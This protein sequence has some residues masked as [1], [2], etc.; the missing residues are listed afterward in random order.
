MVVGKG[1][2]DPGLRRKLGEIDW[3]GEGGRCG[4]WSWGGAA[5]NNLQ[6][7]ELFCCS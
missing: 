6:L 5:G 1:G 2:F 4:R 3:K 7:I